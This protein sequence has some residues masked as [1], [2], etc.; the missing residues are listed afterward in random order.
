MPLIAIA[1]RIEAEIV[2]DGRGL[3][4]RRQTGFSVR[5]GDAR[6]APLVG[7]HM[8]IIRITEMRERSEV[9]VV[10]KEAR[11]VEEIRLSKD[12]DEREETIR[13]NVRHT[14]VDIDNDIDRGNTNRNSLNTD[15]D[16]SDDDNRPG[17][18][19]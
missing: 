10:N 18:V 6:S 16:Y 19:L 12:V 13:E 11:V 15:D 7:G 17:R 8:L 9:P 1:A 5:E 2:M 14:E 4:D 3:D